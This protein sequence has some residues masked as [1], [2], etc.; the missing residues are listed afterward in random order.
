MSVTY[1]DTGMQA[2]SE[3]LAI[4]KPLKISVG[5]FGPEGKERHP[6]APHLA[7]AHLAAI[8]EYGSD[9]VPKQQI[10]L[11][12]MQKNETPLASFQEQQLQAAVQRVTEGANPKQAAIEAMS[13]IGSR[14][15]KLV[16]EQMAAAKQADGSRALDDTG[17]LARNLRWRVHQGRE[18]FAQG[19]S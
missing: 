8:H 13:A 19:D 1:E 11:G 9:D 14:M 16:R 5:Y 3:F 7:V 10:M 15:L 18:T 4:L 2:L 6:N 12:A 17:T